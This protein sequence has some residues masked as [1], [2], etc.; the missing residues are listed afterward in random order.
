MM[1]SI[2]NLLGFNIL[3]PWS[4]AFNALNGTIAIVFALRSLSVLYSVLKGIGLT[5]FPR[6]KVNLQMNDMNQPK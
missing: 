4:F 2:L 6:K 1:L 5:R 3:K